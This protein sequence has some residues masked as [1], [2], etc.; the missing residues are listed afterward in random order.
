MGVFKYQPKTPLQPTPVEFSNLMGFARWFLEQPVAAW[1]PPN[2]GAFQ[3]LFGDLTISGMVLCR[4]PPY[5]VELFTGVG[6]GRVTEHTHP[7]VDSIE[8]AL[9][10]EVT[11]SLEGEIFL[12]NGKLAGDGAFDSCGAML[13][14]RPNRWHGATVGP[15]GGV[16]L[17]IQK[18]LNGVEPSS[19]GTDWEGALGHKISHN[20]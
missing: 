4:I 19:V 17:S 2:N 15:R 5:Q 13:R 11:F 7:N 14:V 6:P 18:W 1:R 20:D 12:D 16:F 8:Y 3:Y 10:G 9:S